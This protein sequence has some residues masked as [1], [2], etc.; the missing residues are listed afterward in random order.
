MKIGGTIAAAGLA[1][2]LV[3]GGCQDR[4]SG[5]DP[6]QQ[7]AQATAQRQ[8]DEQLALYE[9]LRG[10]GRFEV[11]A[12]VGADLLASFPDTTA[13][14]AVR[15]SIEDTRAKALDHD[16]ADRL[17]GL[18]TYHAVAEGDGVVR[19]AQIQARAGDVRLV[20]RRHPEWGQSVYVL[21]RQRLAG[22]EDGC[23]IQVSFDEDAA[24]A[25]Q[26]T[27]SAPQDPPA[28]F[29]EEDQAFIERLTGAGSLE[30]EFPTA[31]QSRTLTYE[32]EGFELERF[33][34]AQP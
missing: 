9:E 8:A 16:E 22:C 20:L 24:E 33:T 5:P 26:A 2:A 21:T 12:K 14:Q 28:V 3:V 18:W 29:V 13:G 7:A 25:W 34:S 6:A 15:D 4:P 1:A 10:S 31:G 32:I 11:A 30:L 27:V 17:A 19:T 23:E